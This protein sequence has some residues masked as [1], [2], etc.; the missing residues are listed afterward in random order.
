MP[1]ALINRR[2]VRS[3]RRSRSN[4]PR[5]NAALFFQ[6][7]GGVPFLKIASNPALVMGGHTMAGA[8]WVN[9]TSVGNP[10]QHLLT[11]LTGAVGTDEY[12]LQVNSNTTLRWGISTGA[13]Y[14]VVNW[15]GVMANATQYFVYFD[16][17]G[18][19]LHINVNNGTAVALAAAGPINTGTSALRFGADGA[20]GV[21]VNASLDAFALWKDRVLSA[22]EQTT[23]Y[24]AGSAW[25]FD[26]VPAQL[27]TGLVSWWDFDGKAGGIWVD[28]FGTNDLTDVNDS[29]T[30][31]TGVS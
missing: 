30:V 20:D 15:S 6:T 21:D 8:G 23:L 10:N 14:Q 11:K 12:F 31:T 3:G 1:N 18:T 28:S 4:F 2:A 7:G 25:R 5:G 13:A 24:N 19:N 9:F 29:V 16:W 22:A 17:D 26:T 27:L